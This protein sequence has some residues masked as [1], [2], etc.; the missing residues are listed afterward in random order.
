MLPINAVLITLTADVR[1]TTGVQI[2][3]PCPA[4]MAQHLPLVAFAQTADA[5]SRELLLRCNPFFPQLYGNSFRRRLLQLL[6][7]TEADQVPE[8][9]GTLFSKLVLHPILQQ[10]P[11]QLRSWWAE[12]HKKDDVGQWAV[13]HGMPTRPLNTKHVA[14]GIVH[15]MY[16]HVRWWAAN[17]VATPQQ[18]LPVG[19]PSSV[20]VRRLR[21][22]GP[23]FTA[24]GTRLCACLALVVGFVTPLVNVLRT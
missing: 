12:W 5:A 24:G 21:V 18:N 1:R 23:C 6:G 3:T 19:S 17:L 8:F 10:L 20:K 4:A 2:V 9:R 7:I 16:P 22:D 14:P 13:V 11:S 15:E